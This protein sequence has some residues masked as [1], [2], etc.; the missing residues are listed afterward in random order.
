LKIAQQQ[1]RVHVLSLVLLQ[2]RTAWN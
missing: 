1:T 2:L